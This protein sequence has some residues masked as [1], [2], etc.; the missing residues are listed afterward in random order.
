[1]GSVGLFMG[2][3]WAIAMGQRWVRHPPH[4]SLPRGRQP[5][6]SLPSAE[7]VCASDAGGSVTSDLTEGVRTAEKVL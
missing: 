4:G 2:W 5:A 3:C 7:G 6:L 1:M